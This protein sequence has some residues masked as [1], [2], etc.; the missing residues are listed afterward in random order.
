MNTPDHKPAPA[1]GRLSLLA[2]GVAALLA[3]TCCLGPLVLVLLGFSGA[4]IGQ[5]TALEPY[6]PVFITTALVALAMAWRQIW[7]S[8][9]A[10]VPGRVCAR[11]GVRRSYKVLFW[12]VAALIAV[13]LGYPYLAPWFY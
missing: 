8:P 13:V 5:L 7:S 12:L 3:S 10:C 2:G 11:P 9:A 4:W 6:R 1:S